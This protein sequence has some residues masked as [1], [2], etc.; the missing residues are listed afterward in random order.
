MGG[1][2]SG[3]WGHHRKATTAEQCRTIN[4][5]AI[6]RG[7]HPP[8]RSGELRWLDGET[9]DSAIGFAV[10]PVEDRV[11]LRLHY[12]WGSD[13]DVL[14]NIA[15]ERVAIP[16][17]GFRWWGQCPLATG[18]KACGRR[19]GKLYL[20]PGS[21]PYF[22][23]RRCHRLGYA[24]SQEYDRRVDHLLRNPE[25]LRAITRSPRGVGVTT[26]GLALKALKIQQARDDRD[27]QRFQKKHNRERGRSAQPDEPPST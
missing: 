15:M 10:I 16:R 5:A 21:S 12:R 14:I 6:V 8:A 25:A 24:S 23:C 19:I 13:R 2:G 4:L 9:V 1:Y 22:G 7:A 26:L 18:D 17:G 3:R 27:F 11:T 20:P